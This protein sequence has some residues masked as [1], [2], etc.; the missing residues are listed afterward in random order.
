[1]IPQTERALLDRCVAAARDLGEQ[2][3]HRTGLARLLG[4]MARANGAGIQQQWGDELLSA[5]EMACEEY[6]RDF[7]AQAPR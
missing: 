6:R 7:P 4:G 1:M 5:W 2:G 3:M